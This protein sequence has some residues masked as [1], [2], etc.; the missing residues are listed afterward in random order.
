MRTVGII[1]EYNPFH[2]G[3]AYQIQKAKQL[4]HADYVI[5]AMSGNYVQ[6]GTPAVVD[7]WKRTAMALQGGADF[8]FELPVCFATAS[9]EYFATAGVSLFAALGC[10]SH[11][12][13]GC[14]TASLPLMQDVAALLTEEPARYRE[15]LTS[16][17]KNG[18]SYPAARAKAVESCLDNLT[19]REQHDLASIFREPNNILAIEYL[20]A[21]RRLHSGLQPLLLL[22]QGSGYHSADLT[23]EFCSASA[24]RSNL[25]APA[26][27]LADYVP[28]KTLDILSDPQTLFLTEQDFSPMLHYKL[29]SEQAQG[30]SDYADCSPELSNR[31]ISLLPNYTDS[32][33]FCELL[34][35]KHITYARVSR[36]LLHILLDIRKKDYQ[37]AAA[38]S[39]APYLRLLGF[40]KDAADLFSQIQN[41]SFRPW[42]TKPSRDAALLPETARR[43]FCKD[44]F[45][46]DLYY[47][48]L[49]EKSGQNQKNELRRALIVL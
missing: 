22:R 36:V 5:V 45:A 42:I 43:L 38:Y 35:S 8:V 19:E 10:V 17:L 3:H 44:V 32:R 40:R 39:Y 46:S 33:S 29:L 23:R 25:T 37:D 47:G 11:L 34:K 30:F 15:R 26:T 12:C 48:I 7:K 41:S 9:A 1:A 14:E 4:S 27:D 2:N 13:F 31:I 16:L 21:I 6:R 49:A 24:I 20:K 28:D 18:L